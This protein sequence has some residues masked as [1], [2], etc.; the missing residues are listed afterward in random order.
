MCNVRSMRRRPQLRRRKREEAGICSKELDCFG[1]EEKKTLWQS[2]TAG[3]RKK[4]S[5]RMTES[6]INRIPGSNDEWERGTEE[7]EASEME[8]LEGGSRR[9]VSA[10]GLKTK[11]AIRPQSHSNQAKKGG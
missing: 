8:Q 2:K 5:E 1:L 9:K 11:E 3:T 7:G 4:T 10:F 6:L